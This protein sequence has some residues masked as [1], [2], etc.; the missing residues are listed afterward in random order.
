[1]SKL[2]KNV[3]LQGGRI[4]RGGF[5]LLE[6]LV[7][8]AIIGIL[9]GLMFPA[10]STMQ[11]N[12]KIKRATADVT[13]LSTAIRGYHLYFHKWPGNPDG[14]AWGVDNYKVIIDLATNGKKVFYEATA[15]NLNQPL[16]DPFGTNAYQIIISGDA[17]TVTSYGPD[18]K[19]GGGDDISASN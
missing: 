8:I 14:G 18:C 19:T 13:A 3:S 6:L 16:M 4:N 12:A 9:A 17:I 1:M 5:T 7:V 2:N 10:F 11:K 15:A